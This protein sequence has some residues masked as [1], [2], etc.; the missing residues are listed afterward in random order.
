MVNSLT[1]GTYFGHLALSNPKAK[2]N[3]T[4]MSLEPV[5]CIII[6]KSDFDKVYNSFNKDAQEKQ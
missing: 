6:W 5:D 3:A 1:V 4:I 2:R